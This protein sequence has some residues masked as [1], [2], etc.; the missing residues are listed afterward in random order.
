MCIP[1]HTWQL[2]FNMLID[3]NKWSFKHDM[4]VITCFSK[5]LRIRE[6]HI[7]RWKIVFM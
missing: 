2:S 3:I 6:K 5:I 7:F 1:S 4:N